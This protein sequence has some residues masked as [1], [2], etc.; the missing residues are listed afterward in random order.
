MTTTRQ[1]SQDFWLSCFCL[2]AILKKAEMLMIYS[3]SALKG[4]LIRDDFEP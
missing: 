1:F 4:S 2:C 3:I